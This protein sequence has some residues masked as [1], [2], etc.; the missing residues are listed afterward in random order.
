MGNA[1]IQPNEDRMFD[2]EFK[3]KLTRADHV[4]TNIISIS[5]DPPGFN[6]YDFAFSGKIFQARINSGINETEPKITVQVQTNYDALVEAEF[7]L[8]VID[9]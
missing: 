9:T 2:F 4:I 3:T 5:S 6:F 1:T 8:P 7:I